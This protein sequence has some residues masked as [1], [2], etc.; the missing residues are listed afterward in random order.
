MGAIAIGRIL[1]LFAQTHAGFTPF[2][3]FKGQGRNTRALV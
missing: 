1:R 3:Q 2:I